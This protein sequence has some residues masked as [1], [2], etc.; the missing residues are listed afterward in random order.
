MS[1]SV[2]DPSAWPPELA[3]QIEEACNRFEAAWRGGDRPRI[4]AYL[5]E[6]PEPGRSVLLRELLALE[7]E[8]RVGGGD[9][10]T[11]REYDARFPGHADLVREVVCSALP[12]SP[13]VLG[14]DAAGTRGARTSR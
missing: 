11:P 2:R 12:A 1:S 14:R 5:G 9:A 7:L 4:E 3:L 8:Y 6:A 13:N 10:P